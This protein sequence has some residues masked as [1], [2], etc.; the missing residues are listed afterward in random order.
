MNA[1]AC[2]RLMRPWQWVK[3][4]F[5]FLPPLFAGRILDGEPL[6]CACAAFASFCL[7]AS[8][9]YCF[10]DYADREA[11]RSHP[12]KRVRP[13]ASGTVRPGAAI[14]LGCAL[15]CAGLAVA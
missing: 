10:N 5:V 12:E 2:I 13:V 3:N 8:G 1:K 15:A 4:G 11:D 6:A 9:V 7:V 14:A